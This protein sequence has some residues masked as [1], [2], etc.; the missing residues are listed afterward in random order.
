MRLT[1]NTA[2]TH[3]PVDL[4]TLKRHLRVDIDEDDEEI[5]AFALAAREEVEDQTGLKLVTQTWTMYLDEFSAGEIELP[6]LPVQAVTWIKYYDS[7]NTLATWGATNY[8]SDY[9]S[10][11][12]PA[13]IRPVSG[14]S[15]PSTYDRMAA[16]EV[17]FNAGFGNWD[18]VPARLR[19]AIMVLTATYYEHREDVVPGVEVRQLVGPACVARLVAPYKVWTP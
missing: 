1:M 15:W 8:Q 16:V 10:R 3:E 4:E 7:T 19:Q 12:R 5:T 2:P 18:D 9:A 11:L 17:K 13:R 6:F 14:V